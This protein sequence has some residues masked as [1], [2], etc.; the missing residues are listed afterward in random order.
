MKLFLIML[1]VFV[2]LAVFMPL[3]KEFEDDQD[4]SDLEDGGK[5][6]KP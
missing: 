5:R 6:G 3:S 4:Y 1:G 2:V